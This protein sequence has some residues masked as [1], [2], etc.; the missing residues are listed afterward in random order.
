MQ[1]A[2]L[3]V[4]MAGTLNVVFFECPQRFKIG[5]IVT[6]PAFPMIGGVPHVLVVKRPAPE[7]A[8]TATTISHLLDSSTENFELL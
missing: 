3:A 6:L 8:V 1:V 5:V 4:G 2:I 7:G